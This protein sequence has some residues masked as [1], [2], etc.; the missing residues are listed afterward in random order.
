MALALTMA[1]PT[2]AGSLDAYVDAVFRIPLLSAEQ[3][4]DLAR[5]L[6]DDGDLAAA[7]ELVLSHLRFVVSVARGYQGYGLAQS[8]LIQEGNIGLMKA[9]K[10][11]DPEVGVRLVSFAVHW[12]KAEIHEFILRNWRIVKVATT[13]AQRKLFFNL[14][15]AKKSL[16]W[17]G[18]QEVDA[19]AAELG[20]EARDV[21]TME[22]RLHAHDVA[23]DLG[24][25]ADDHPL[26][27]AAYL[28]DRRFEPAAL[29]DRSEHEDRSHEGLHEALAALDARSRD[30][31]VSRWL[32]EPKATLHDLA[33][34]YGVSA[35]RIRQIEK[36]AFGALKRALP[37]F[38]PESFD[39]AG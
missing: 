18:A 6:R 33:A 9:V 32:T 24:P 27:P 10:R 39:Q 28:E 38:A 21:T 13:K 30:I 23:F 14:R 8:D 4:Q 16:G 5:R 2:T 22:Q 19:M 26:V 1:V 11:F 37:E 25:D 7:R 29:L 36:N 31:V 3:E 34:R 15:S 20:V 17:M 35:E 12:I